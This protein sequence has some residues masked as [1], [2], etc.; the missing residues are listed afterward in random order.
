MP[1]AHGARVSAVTQ[2]DRGR[3]SDESSETTAGR[4]GYLEKISVVG[5]D[6]RGALSE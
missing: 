4:K 2:R 6:S 3:D 5:C 1:G